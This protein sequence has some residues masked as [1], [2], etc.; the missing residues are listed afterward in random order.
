M[1][2]E[3]FKCFEQVGRLGDPLPVVV[4]ENTRFEFVLVYAVVE[5]VVAIDE[6]LDEYL[7]EGLPLVFVE[8]AVFVDVCKVKQLE[9]FLVVHVLVSERQ[10][11]VFL[12]DGLLLFQGVQEV[13][14]T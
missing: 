5:V 10:E 3:A 4:F 9:H 12:R 7:C 1:H 14:F 6:G 13:F 8:H 11:E 2:V